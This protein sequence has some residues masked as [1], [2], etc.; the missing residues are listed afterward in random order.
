MSE[1]DVRWLEERPGLWRL[2]HR[3]T[4]VQRWIATDHTCES[5]SKPLGLAWSRGVDDKP[6]PVPVI[7]PIWSA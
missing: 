5:G 1:P 7:E 4:G 6:K 2:W 3:H